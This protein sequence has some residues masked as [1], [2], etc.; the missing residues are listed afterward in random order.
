[1]NKPRDA[2][3]AVELPEGIEPTTRRLQN[4]RSAS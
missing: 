1:M 4:G 3:P 2:K